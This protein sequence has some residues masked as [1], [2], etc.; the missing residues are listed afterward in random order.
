VGKDG[1][2]S[3]NYVRLSMLDRMDRG[4]EGWSKGMYWSLCDT[5][6]KS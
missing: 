3:L 6:K 5:G 2:D 4:D 1:I